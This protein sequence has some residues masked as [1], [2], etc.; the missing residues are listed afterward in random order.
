MIHTCSTSSPSNGKHWAQL[1][2]KPKI[3]GQIPP[4]R[5]DAGLIF[6][7]TEILLLG[8]TTLEDDTESTLK[9]RGEHPQIYVLCLNGVEPVPEHFTVCS[10]E[11]TLDK[12]EIII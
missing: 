3:E 11:N 8:G 5:W 12:P 1:R 7:N 10:N 6:V 4:P 2:S 9:D